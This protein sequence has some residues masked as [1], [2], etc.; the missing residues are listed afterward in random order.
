MILDKG[1]CTVY[2]KENTAAPGAMPVWTDV[3]YHVS[4]Y[5]ELSFETREARP[6]ENREEVRCDARIRV[7]QNRR[8]NNHDRVEL[9]QPDGES[10]VYE[11]TRAY[12]G[13]D[14]ESGELISDLSLEVIEP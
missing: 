2:R 3:A 13:V 1:I 11:V 8:I 10:L 5:G 7:L 6:T 9:R 14:D 4:W 12:H